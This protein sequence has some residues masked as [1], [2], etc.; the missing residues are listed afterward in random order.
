MAT[1]G[2]WGVLPGFPADLN[3]FMFAATFADSPGGALRRARLREFL[4]TQRIE[5]QARAIEM[6]YDYY[7]SPAVVQD[8]SLAD[9]PDPWGTEYRQ[10][11]RPGHRL[12]HAWLQREGHRLSTHDLLRTG[13]FLMLTG[14]DDEDWSRAADTAAEQFGVAIDR[15]RIDDGTWLKLRDHD[16]S[17]ALLVRPDG[18]IAFRAPT[19][20]ADHEQ[21]IAVAIGTALGV[22]D[23][24]VPNPA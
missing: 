6:G 4:A 12:P 15:V 22:V 19:A 17:G 11:T 21:A 10:N 7:A 1:S 9:A 23:A 13:E 18:H 3:Q 8:G 16:D 14:A 24:R 20:V 5:F 2:G